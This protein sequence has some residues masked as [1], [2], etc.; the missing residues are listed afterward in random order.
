MSIYNIYYWTMGYNS[1][2]KYNP[3]KL[4]NYNT[5]EICVISTGVL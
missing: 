1:S 5:N 4:Y 2:K 3:T